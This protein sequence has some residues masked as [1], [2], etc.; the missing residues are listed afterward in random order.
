MINITPGSDIFIEGFT[1]QGGRNQSDVG[2]ALFANGSTVVISSTLIRD[3]VAQSGG[4][5]YV[6]GGGAPGVPLSI[7]NSTFISNTADGASA[8]TDAGNCGHA[9]VRNTTIKENT[10]W[11]TVAF[12]GTSFEMV[13]SQV[14]SN[15]TTGP[16]DLAVGTDG[17]ISNTEFL[18]HTHQAIVIYAGEVWANKIT[19]RDG[20][21]GGISNAGV[22]TLSD[23]LLEDNAGGGA[24]AVFCENNAAPESVGLTIEGC[25]FR[26]ND[27]AGD[28]W[29][30]SR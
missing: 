27:D 4:G 3:N 17:T 21:G 26:N 22:L 5:V 18:S 23:S 28:G 9:L 6:E 8:F 11:E 10:G 12:N 29:R 14:I 20:Q 24:G 16:G 30:Q 13:D 2:G 1:I 25:T 15:A 7:I 19:V